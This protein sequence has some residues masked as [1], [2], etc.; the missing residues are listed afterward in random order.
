[1]ANRLVQESSPYLRQHRDNPVDWYAWG[2]EAFAK[3]K[4]EDKPILLSVGYSSC[5]WCHVMAHES[6]ED[7]ETAELVNQ[8]FVNVKVDR[9]ERPD[10]DAVYMEFVVAT[11]GQGGWPMTVFLTPDG[12]PFYGGTYFPKVG[13]Q[14]MPSFGQLCEAV[15]Q[16]WREHRDDIEEQ[17]DRILEEISRSARL[18]PDPDLP[19]ADTVELALEQLLK[20][21]DVTWGG[22]GRAPKFPQTMSLDLLLQVHRRTGDPVLLEA[23]TTSLA[24]M[25]RGGIYDHVGGGFSRYSVDAFWMVPHFEKMLYDNALLARTYLHA[26]QVTGD[27]EHLQVVEEVIGYVQR[28]LA[29]SDGGVTSA[30][31]ADSEGEE[32]R[33]YVWKRSQLREVLGEQADA[34]IEWWGVTE[35]GNFEGA[36]ILHRPQGGS[37]L[38]SAEVEAARARLFEVRE[39]RAR[40][41]LDDK[42][43]TEWNALWLA[44]LAEAAFA[45][46]R[47]DWLAA[48]ERLGELLLRELRREDGRWLRSWQAQGGARHLAFASDHAALVDA[49][50]RLSE[51]TGHAR[52]LDEAV[53]TADTM[54]ELFWDAE[55]GGLFTTGSDAEALVARQKD[56]QDNAV[57]SANSQAAL[58]FLRLASLTGEAR[59]LE[60]AEAILRL[61][62]RYAKSHPMGFALL[63]QAVDLH[64][65]GSTEVVVAGERP[66][67]VDE[68]RARFLPGAVLA[69]GE[70][71]DS[72]LWADRVDG[73]AYVCK[74]FTCQLPAE[75]AA[76]LVAQ[77][78]ALG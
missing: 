45:T 5:H 67:L 18:E 36:T 1:M 51:A 28:D 6:F 52:W 3:A 63:L 69:W 19:S 56:F 30:E 54:L 33:F 74:D 73:R 66:D 35:G 77:L 29:T 25:A 12:A 59:W 20:A 60:H 50:T 68:L 17:T 32:G 15:D 23:V 13:R 41:G 24:A 78:D 34:A 48:A 62:G 40:P 2:P 8:L 71:R 4:A 75:D 14:G 53:A 38:R 26:W 57:P 46:G 31:D 47:A 16:H 42:V 55:H 76:T 64:Q 11:T 43:L 10:V 70:R 44:T 58:A 37:L 9:E 39:Q 49:F 61:F 27:P 72:P 7:E 21:H 22:F 65:T